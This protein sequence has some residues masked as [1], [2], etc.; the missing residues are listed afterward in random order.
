MADVE[1][2]LNPQGVREILESDEALA[3]CQEHA[4]DIAKRCGDGYASAYFKG[5]DRWKSTVYADS[6][7][8]RK[9]NSQNN[10]ILKAVGSS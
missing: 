2:V 10:T 8:A 7:D 4:A 6:E 1:I 3:I 9:D 5:T